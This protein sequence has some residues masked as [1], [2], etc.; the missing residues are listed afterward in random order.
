MATLADALALH[1]ADRLD[2]AERLYDQLLEADPEH[3]DALHLKGVAR[4]QRGDLRDAVRLIGRAIVQRPDDAAFYSNLAAALY[5]LQ[6]YGQAIE[7]ASRSVALDAG[8]F[9]SRMIIGQCHEAQQQWQEAADAYRDALALDPRNRNLINGR[10]SA[11]QALDQHSEIVAFIDSLP[12]PIDDV[13]RIAR[14]SALRVGRRFE[15]AFAELRACRHQAGHDWHVTMLKTFLDSGDPRGALP[16]GQALLEAK[17]KLADERFALRGAV[18]AGATWPQMSAFRPNDEQA[19]ERNVVCFSLWGDN[20]KYT[21]NAVLNAK[22]VPIVYPGWSARFYVD[23]SVPAEIVQALVDYGA[24]VIRVQT[25]ERTHLKLFWRFLATDDPGVERFICRD[26]DAVVNH[27]EQAAVREWIES[28]R[29]F[30]VMRDHPEHAELMMA[31]MWGGVA[32]L[33]PSLSEQAVQYYE[34]HEPK[35]RWVDQDFLR[36]RVWPIIKT[37]CLVHDD[38]YTMGGECRPF[39]PGSNLSENEHVGGYRPRFA[40]EQGHAS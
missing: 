11:L 32:G 31:G 30:H 17:D 20:P 27:R 10:L 16:H 36:D 4:M 38:F 3:P 22:K 9:Q 6:M 7:Y 24:R 1:R 29:R 19:P 13:L 35:W 37:D 26:C 12:M 39:P 34:T 5:R 25:D 8:S 18:P 21:Y 14:A 2:E 40:A 28:G 23:E 15:E 33:L